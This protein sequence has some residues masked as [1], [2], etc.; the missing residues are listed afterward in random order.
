MKYCKECGVSVGNP[1][2]H[3]PLCHAYLERRDAEPEVPSYPPVLQMAER[4]NLIQRVLVMLSLTVSLVC[5]TI[6]LLVSARPL[7][8][9]IVISG[10]L[11][12]WVAIGSAVRR[13]ARLGYNILIQVLSLAVLLVVIDWFSGHQG[14]SL[15]YVVPFLFVCATASI[16]VIIIVRRMDIRGF[17]LYF[18]LMALLGF[19]PVILLAFGLVTVAWPSLVAAMYSGLSLI[20]LFVFAD[21]STKQ[22]LK[23]R[24]HL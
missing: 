9:L 24:F 8:S 5:L 23:K 7:W 4:Y 13:A 2:D 22:E 17:V 21:R 14:W 3:C 15:N 10:I 20:G 18:F 6:N 11:Y 1:L 16:T 19:V 12:M